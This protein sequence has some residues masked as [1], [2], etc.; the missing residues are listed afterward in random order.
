MLQQ[1]RLKLMQSNLFWN[2]KT[3]ER[4]SARLDLW[5]RLCA[6]EDYFWDAPRDLQP[7]A[8]EVDRSQR[9][10]VLLLRVPTST[11]DDQ[12]CMSFF[13]LRH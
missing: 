4:E 5:Q 2:G 12:L 9:F 3:H 13:A 6:S 10:A 11:G 1:L 8:D 7:V